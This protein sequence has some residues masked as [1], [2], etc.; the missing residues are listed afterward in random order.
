MAPFAVALIITYSSLF[1]GSMRL[2]CMI[3]ELCRKY[4]SIETIQGATFI[5][6][7]ECSLGFNM[8]GGGGMQ[9]QRPSTHKGILHWPTEWPTPLNKLY[10]E[11]YMHNLIVCIYYK[12]IIV[13]SKIIKISRLSILMQYVSRTFDQLLKAK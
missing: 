9:P 13:K 8:G 4:V 5:F 7:L 2:T 3:Y 11:Q 1:R 6:L 12:A 10:N